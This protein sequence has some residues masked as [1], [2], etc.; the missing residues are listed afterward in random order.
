MAPQV[1][2]NAGS[3]A[4]EA[5]DCSHAEDHEHN[6]GCDSHCPIGYKILGTCIPVICPECGRKLERMGI[7]VDWCPGCEKRMC[8]GKII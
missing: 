8:E 1:R 3:C 2:C 4:M 5:E 6:A 7:V